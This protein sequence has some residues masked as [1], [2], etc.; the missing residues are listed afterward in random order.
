MNFDSNEEI[1]KAISK[2][3]EGFDFAIHEYGD[4]QENVH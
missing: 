4:L 3:V 1:K 2:I